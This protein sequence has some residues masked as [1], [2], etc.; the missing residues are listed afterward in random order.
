M[1]ATPTVPLAPTW[2]WL[3]PLRG[4]GHQMINKDI[5]S[6][7]LDHANRSSEVGPKSIE[8]SAPDNLSITLR[9][10]ASRCHDLP[11]A[12]EAGQAVD[13]RHRHPN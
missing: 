3:P 2:K 11:D 6:G 4:P 10:D 13:P 12:G 9:N 5:Q 7:V 1:V 8:K